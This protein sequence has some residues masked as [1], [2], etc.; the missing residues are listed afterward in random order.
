MQFFPKREQG[1]GI[2]TPQRTEM[3]D[4]CVARGAQRNQPGGIMQAGLP[5]VH[6]EP[7]ARPTALTLALVT[8]QDI[9]TMP[10]EIDVRVI[11]PLVTATTQAQAAQF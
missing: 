3:M 8:C 5:M 6:L 7:V 1:L 2:P 11:G 10:T 9:I 4:A